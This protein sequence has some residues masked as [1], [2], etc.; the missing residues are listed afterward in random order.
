M[1]D[2]LFQIVYLLIEK[3]KM[4]ARELAEIF[5]V[6]E[7]TI[8]RDLD[9]LTL[10]GVPV[11]TSQGKNGGIS[12]LPDYVLDKS[13]LTVEEKGKIIESLNALNE[14][15]PSGDKDAVAKLRSFL[16]EEYQDWI[17]IEFSGWG[18][19]KEEGVRFAQLKDAILK[20]QYVEITYSGNRKGMLKRKIKPL[21]LCFK[22]QAWYLYAYC[23]LRE[24]YR[25]FKLKRMSQLE[26]SDKHFEPEAVGKVLTEGTRNYVNTKESIRVTL[27]ISQEMAFRAYEELT[28]VSIM[29]NG[30]LRC[31]MEINDKKWFTSYVL[32]YGS[33]MRI[34]E[35]LEI[36]EYVRQEIESMKH[37]YEESNGR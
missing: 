24:D 10:A 11:Y 6:S 37:L 27:E 12:I 25:F 33:H 3:P 28:D 5:E 9:K 36:K 21:K 31:Q 34:L 35:P 7:R 32:S 20:H 22:E 15:S 13:V 16:G 17:E 26:V 4:T 1:V 29:D 23:C 30:K 18:N 2:R 14:V 8:Y 19:S